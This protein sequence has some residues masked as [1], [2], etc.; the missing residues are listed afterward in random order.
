MNTIL[1]FSVVALCTIQTILCDCTQVRT[2]Q[3]W[4]QGKSQ[5]AVCHDFHY[6]SFEGIPYAKSPTGSLRFKAPEEPDSWEGTRDATAP[7]PMCPQYHPLSDKTYLGSEDCLTCDV[8]TRNV[9]KKAPV[10]FFLSGFAYFFDQ[11]VT[12][13]YGPDFLVKDIVVVRCNHRKDVLGFLNLGI[14]DVAGNGGLKDN[15]AALRWVKKNIA[16]FG[17]DPDRV[18]LAGLSSGS[19]AVSHLLYSPMASGLFEKAFMMSGIHSCDPVYPDAV[20]E[21][22]YELAARLGIRSTD[23]DEVL[24]Q[25]QEIPY[26]Q[27][28]NVS[29]SFALEE[30]T[31]VL[32]KKMATFVPCVEE[33]YGQER[34]IIEDAM[35]SLYH[36]PMN[37]VKLMM[38]YSENEALLFIDQYYDYIIDLYSK[39]KELCVPYKILITSPSDVYEKADAIKKYYFQ[40]KDICRENMK[41]FIQMNSFMNMIF[42]VI[43][44]ASKVSPCME[45]YLFEFNSISDRNIYGREGL[46]YGLEG[47]AHADLIGYLFP[48]TTLNM[49]LDM[50]SREHDLIVQFLDPLK[51]FIHT[52]NPSSNADFTWHRYTPDKPYYMEFTDTTT[53]KE[54]PK[55]DE[56]RFWLNE[57]YDGY[58]H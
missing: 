50:K 28:I 42:E 22:S 31:N 2:E 49:T 24:Q 21:K 3:G 7:G 38:G 26:E 34:V 47:T 37:N 54:D 10:F 17:G 51:N 5:E 43:R 32:F 40:N 44:F 4:V 6:L 18:V 23:G 27:F 58:L 41:E 13:V 8:Y 55:G 12:G 53:V 57:I 29:Y 19:A 1:A 56:Y 30:P 48:A 16:A 20:M 11:E 39:R 52:G 45:T 46:K 9:T 36:A 35:E 25:L 14:K 33:D 15:I